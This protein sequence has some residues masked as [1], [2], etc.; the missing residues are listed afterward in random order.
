[1]RRTALILVGAITGAVVLGVAW[2]WWTAPPRADV[3]VLAEAAAAIPAGADGL[4]VVAQPNGAVHWLLR[5]PQAVALLELSAPR[6]DEALTR[7]RRSLETLAREAHGPLA[8]WW[9]GTEMA[10]S[11]RVAG[12]A[13]RALRTLAALEAV[14]A[15]SA[16]SVADATVVSIASN[17]ALLEGPS[18]TGPRFGGPERLSGIA[19]LGA[20]WWRIRATRDRLDLVAGTPPELPAREGPSTIITGDIG[21][22]IGPALSSNAL[23]QAS[24]GLAFDADGWAL[25]LPGTPLGPEVMRMLTLGGDTPASPPPG[26]RAWRGVLGEV[27]A[28]PG[29]GLTIGSRATMLASLPS[30]PY[31]GESGMLRGP[32]LSAVCLR[33][34]DA[35]ERLWV[36]ESRATALRRAA[37]LVAQVRLARW[38]ILPEGGRIRLEW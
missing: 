21:R 29:P 17:S 24:A 4:L 10:A 31:A 36:F 27:W 25:A 6:T 22:L 28:L 38:R 26:A 12:G 30:P 20:R 3:S 35:L 37:P 15:R 14:P 2:W 32:E 16:P 1:M 18:G 19:R 5:R 11:A 7:L 33:T 9:R 13:A 23:S 34:A 8:V